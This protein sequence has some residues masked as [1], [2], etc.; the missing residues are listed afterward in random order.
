MYKYLFR[1][2]WPYRG[3]FRS[4]QSVNSNMTQAT[5]FWNENWVPFID[6]AIQINI[7]RNEGDKM[8]C[9]RFVQQ[10]NIDVKQHILAVQASALGRN[11]FEA[12]Y[13]YDTNTTRYDNTEQ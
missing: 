2:L 12:I 8:V 5:I 13:S 9:P 11:I 6:A 1:F 7:L 4:I 3:E 10:L